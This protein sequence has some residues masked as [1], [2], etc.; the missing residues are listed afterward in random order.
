MEKTINAL[1][2]ALLVI[3]KIIALKLVCL[4]VLAVHIKILLQITVYHNVHTH[5]MQI[6]DLVLI[7]AFSHV[8]L[9]P[10]YMLMITLKNVYLSVLLII[11]LLELYLI[12]KIFAQIFVLMVIMP[13]M[14]LV[15]AKLLAVQDLK[16][17]NFECV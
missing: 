9:L 2:N 11:I 3:S 16:M 7:I 10:C 5:I 4:F 13:I 14:I 17:M 12:V 15:N 6:I 8:L 1:N